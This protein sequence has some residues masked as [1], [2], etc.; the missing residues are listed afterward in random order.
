MK[1][2]ELMIGD[3][4][5]CE[6]QPIPS[7][8]TIEEVFDD[9]VIFKGIHYEGDASLDRIF[10]IPLTDEILKKNGFDYYHKNFV[11]TDYDS[12]FKLE[13]VGWPDE[14]GNGGLWLINGLFKIRFVHELQH[15]LRLCEIEKEIVL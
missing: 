14:N 12:P 5:F 2:T 1:A 3:W 6:G 7:N 11:S 15:A 10:P 9:G 8:A 13:M 4:V